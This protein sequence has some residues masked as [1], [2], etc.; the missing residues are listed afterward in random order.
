[1]EGN[2]RLNASVAGWTTS[3]LALG[4]V[5]AVLGAWAA[6]VALVGPSFSYGFETSSSWR[7]TAAHWELSIGPGLLALA[8]GLLLASASVSRA[9]L[10]AILGL[11]AGFWLT[12][13]PFVFPLWA[14]EVT[15]HAAAD[16]KRML[17]WLGWYVG[18]GALIAS[19][20]S[21]ALGLLA[22][23]PLPVPVVF[24]E[25]APAEAVAETEPV[26]PLPAPQ[27]ARDRTSV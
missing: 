14:S 21:L 7:F 20:S 11:V 16:W 25:P 23:R 27:P 24:A 6:V 2:R 17:L 1:M 18:I 3:H 8:A 15:P 5:I 10:G 26:E 9:R 13:G 12:A 4:V 19:L 22:R